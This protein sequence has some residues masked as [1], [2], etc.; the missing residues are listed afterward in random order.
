MLSLLLA[1]IVSAEPGVVD[2]PPRIVRWHQVG[3]IGIGMSRGRV[4]AAY[5]L[6]RRRANSLSYSLHG[7]EVIVQYR[8]GRVTFIQVS[9]PYYRAPNGFGVGFRIPLGPCHDTVASSCERRW[10]G[11]AYDGCCMWA[12]WVNWKSW[13]LQ[14]IANVERGV[15]RSFSFG[16]TGPAGVSIEP[17]VSVRRAIAAALRAEMCRQSYCTARISDVRLSKTNRAYA[18]AVV[19]LATGG[20]AAV[21]H[22]TG[23]TWNVVSGPGSS[24]VG[25]GVAPTRILRDLDL[26]C[27]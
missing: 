2:D 11:F 19:H 20:V 14:L 13:Q 15:V 7:G 17:P 16:I 5:G 27:Q 26:Y 1:P 24:N 21:L 4:E 9:T 6:P 18:A 8:R 12:R 23:R 22:R 10:H 25:C 3:D